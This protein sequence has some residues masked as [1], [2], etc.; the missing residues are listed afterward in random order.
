MSIELLAFVFG[1]LLLFVAIVGGGFELRELKVPRVG[2]VA[3]VVS[4]LLGVLF[5]MV[6]FSGSTMEPIG[7]APAQAKTNETPVTTPAPPAPPEPADPVDFT[8]VD[9]LGELQITEQITVQIDGRKVGTLTVDTVH[10]TSE[11]TVTVP[12]PGRYDYTL[13]SQTMFDHDGEPVE[14]PGYGT[15]EI[16]VKDGSSFSVVYEFGEE[17]LVLSLE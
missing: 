1:I 3:R 15:G 4:A 9:Q 10:E 7:Q 11:L 13:E 14:I 5:L 12:E 2:K 16:D 6:G 8:V 17:A